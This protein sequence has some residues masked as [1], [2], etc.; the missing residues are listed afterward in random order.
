MCGNIQGLSSN[1]ISDA[2]EN[3]RLASKKG[4]IPWGDGDVSRE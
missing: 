1:D 4:T 3:V 2:G